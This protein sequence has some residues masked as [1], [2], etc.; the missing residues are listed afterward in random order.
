MYL[1]LFVSN[2][3]GSRYMC[4]GVPMCGDSEGNTA[5]RLY[6]VC[7]CTTS[8]FTC[9]LIIAPMTYFLS[10]DV[11]SFSIDFSVEKREPSTTTGTTSS[12]G[13]AHVS[14]CILD[15]SI[16]GMDGVMCTYC[17]ALT[18]TMLYSLFS[19]RQSPGRE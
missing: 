1:P 4:R 6:Y 19:H 8:W 10:H 17:Y 5:C 3:G 18:L 14:V 2:S 11:N 12:L 7:V 13:C 15:D 16:A 9:F